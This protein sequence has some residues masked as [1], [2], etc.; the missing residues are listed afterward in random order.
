MMQLDLSRRRVAA[1]SFL[2]NISLQD[3]QKTDEEN[4]HCLRVNIQA[5]LIKPILQRI[6]LKSSL[7]EVNNNLDLV[8]VSHYLKESFAKVRGLNPCSHEDS[9]K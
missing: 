2:S 7:K 9:Q 3:E 6:Y 8:V 1:I 4:L 5:S